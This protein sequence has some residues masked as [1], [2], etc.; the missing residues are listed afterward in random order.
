MREDPIIYEDWQPG[1]ASKEFIRPMILVDNILTQFICILFI[2]IGIISRNSVLIFTFTF[3]GIAMLIIEYFMDQFKRLSWNR[4]ITIISLWFILL[5]F[6]NIEL[7][8]EFYKILF[9]VIL[10]LKLFLVVLILVSIEVAGEI[11]KP[12]SDY[13]KEKLNQQLNM[14]TVTQYAIKDSNIIARQHL[15][16]KLIIPI[17]YGVLITIIIVALLQITSGIVYTIVSLLFFF[18]LISVSLTTFNI[19]YQWNKI[20]RKNQGITVT[21]KQRII[22]RITTP[23]KNYKTKRNRS[24]ELMTLRM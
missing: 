18:A 8:D 4:F 3:F 7:V 21:I 22:S 16:R 24:K 2:Y 6:S 14:L 17:S 12:K 15:F 23:I 11:L 9:S 20:K 13:S 19:F 1:I 5:I 10:S